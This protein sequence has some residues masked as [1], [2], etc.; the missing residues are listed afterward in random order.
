MVIYNLNLCK[1]SFY[2]CDFSHLLHNLIFI[3][4]RKTGHQFKIDNLFQV[5]VN[6][7]FS[8]SVIDLS[9]CKYIVM[10]NQLNETFFEFNNS[11]IVIFPRDNSRNPFFS[12]CFNNLEITSLDVAKSLAIS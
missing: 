5:C 4:K 11:R 12:N 7:I 6:Y 10:K 3:I 9:I 1:F 2:L 8:Y